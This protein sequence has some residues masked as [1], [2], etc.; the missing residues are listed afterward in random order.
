MTPLLDVILILMFAILING[1]FERTQMEASDINE[2][3]ALSEQIIELSQNVED[4]KALVDSP[5]TSED[6]KKY[7]ALK[8]LVKIIDVRLETSENAL[9]LDG[10]K[11]N[12]YLLYDGLSTPNQIDA[13]KN[14]LST[15]FLEKM[16][17]PSGVALI[18]LKEDGEVYRYA[19]QL[20]HNVILELVKEQGRDKLYYVELD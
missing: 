2:S 1:Q 20:V 14:R 3:N 11:T 10:V 8:D 6:L 18:T 19:Y 12:V 16:Q 7:D 15:L 5:I 17:Q 4:L 13:Q 9:T